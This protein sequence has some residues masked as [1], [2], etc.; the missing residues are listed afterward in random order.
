MMIYKK[1]LSLFFLMVLLGAC[2]EAT[3][4]SPTITVTMAT[5]T[6]SAS[7]ESATPPPIQQTAEWEAG[8]EG[9]IAGI[10]NTIPPQRPIPYSCTLDVPADI[11]DDF[12]A[13]Y[14]AWIQENVLAEKWAELIENGVVVNAGNPN[15]TLTISFRF[16]CQQS[17]HD[18]PGATVSIIQPDGTSWQLPERVGF[19]LSNHAE[20]QILWDGE[21][22]ILLTNQQFAYWGMSSSHFVVWHITPNG[23]S[24]RTESFAIPDDPAFSW[25][26]AQPP[27]IE[28]DGQTHFIAGSLANIEPP[29][30]FSSDF[31][32]AQYGKEVRYT[33]IF[34]ELGYEVY[35]EPH[36]TYWQDDGSPILDWEKYCVEN[37]TVKVTEMPASPTPTPIPT[38][39][40]T[41]TPIP[42]LMPTPFPQPTPTNPPPP[43]TPQTRYNCQT[44]TTIVPSE[45]EGLVSLHLSTNGE[46]WLD[47]RGWLETNTPCD[48]NGVIC[49]GEHVISLHLA[50][51]N[52]VGEMP[53]EIGNLTH[54]RNLTLPGNKLSGTL[55]STL[56][57]LTQL[58][59]LVL[60][61]NFLSGNIPPVLAELTQLQ[62]LVLSGNRFSGEMP[63]FLVTLPRLRTL[64]LSGNE[65]LTGPLPRAL[66][67][68]GTDISLSYA[69][70]NLCEPTDD[71]FQAWWH[72]IYI[73]HE[74]NP[75]D[76]A[77]DI[78][79]NSAIITQFTSDRTFADAGDI[80]T[81]AWQVENGIDVEIEIGTRYLFSPPPDWRYEKHVELENAGTI[82]YQIEERTCVTELPITIY[83]KDAPYVEPHTQT[84]EITLPARTAV[85]THVPDI[86]DCPA[87]AGFITTIVEQPF[88]HGTMI[89]IEET[90]RI[91]ALIENDSR[92]VW[93]ANDSY[94]PQT[95]PISDDNLIPPNGL[96]QPQFGLGKVWREM[97]SLR[98]GLGWATAP[99]QSFTA[100]YQGHFSGERLSSKSI[101]V[102][103]GLDGFLWRIDGGYGPFHW[104]KTDIPTYP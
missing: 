34:T 65:N 82:Q 49:W 40:A 30:T 39:Q 56:H 85:I 9:I 20:K 38:T 71:E 21:K 73:P 8:L 48:W 52:L 16:G 61:T 18:N 33:Y 96:F 54:L 41:A 58:E 42:T 29:C 63:P 31:D 32:P 46:Q 14:L 13:R 97:P 100:P 103:G 84:V 24:W 23:D 78:A 87:K 6:P 62:T 44:A 75:C 36:Y 5:A 88:E 3:P 10:Q 15:A 1:I 43:P 81:I 91:F 69:Y 57:Q 22:W 83:V 4:E 47:K 59:E 104:T 55:P 94:N 50:G 17:S 70:T 51:N 95:D 2:R 101:S 64:V 45:C 98:D 53:A 86:P 68:R 25:A 99:E 90:G 37:V 77:L 27:T 26:N 60:D 102:F 19:P 35:G 79:N 66:I 76:D 72:S 67:Q 12:N 74:A 93:F 28:L 92:A 11:A 89:W 7:I 80:I